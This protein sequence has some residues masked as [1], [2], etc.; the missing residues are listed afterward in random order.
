MKISTAH[1]WPLVLIIL[2]LAACGGDSD[3]EGFAN[4]TATFEAGAATVNITAP[5]SGSIIYAESIRISG[6]V[7]GSPQAFSIRLLTP[8]EQVI[9]ETD[10]DAQPGEWQ[11]ELVHG[12]TGTPTEV[13]IM[14]TGADGTVLDTSTVLLSDVSN[15]P[16]GSIATI[17]LP[18]DGDTVGGD[19]IPVQGRASG[20]EGGLLTLQL[21]DSADNVID[22][23]TMN[24]LNPFVID[25]VP[26]QADLERRDATG[27]A[28]I[29]LLSADEANEFDRVAVTLSEAAG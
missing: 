21:V 12:F 23:E 8:D 9:T 19:V 17:T 25:D 27:S 16:E 20:I 24:L 11:V 10:V 29:R 6:E 15:R 2:L 14:A 1:L 13:E 7:L 22:S 26:W 3:S 18:L 28:T 4:P 5:P